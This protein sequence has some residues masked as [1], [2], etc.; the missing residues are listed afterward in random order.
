MRRWIPRLRRA[1]G[2][3]LHLSTLRRYARAA[4]YAWK[5]CRRSLRPQRD[6]AAFAACQARLAELHRAEARGAG[7]VVYVDECRFSR[8]APVPWNLFTMVRMK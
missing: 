4:G 6:P 7:A 3:R 1:F 2:V 8:H 5:R